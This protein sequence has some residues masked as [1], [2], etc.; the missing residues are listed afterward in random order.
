MYL[1][2]NNKSKFYQVVYFENG[3]RTTISTKSTHEREAQEFLIKFKFNIIEKPKKVIIQKE[4]C[5]ILSQ[6]KNEYFNYII[7]IKSK[8]YIR[9]IL[10]SFKQL[11]SF[12]GDIP[13]NSIDVKNIDH[14]VTSTFSRTKT[15]AHLYYRTLKAAFNK[16]IT[17]NYIS[18][19][20]FSKV[21]FPRISKSYPIFITEDE[22]FIILSNTSQKYLK[23]IFTVAFYSGLRISE[24]LNM[25]WNWINFFQ[26]LITVK[27]SNEF[28][29]KSKKERII[30]M[31]ERIRSILLSRFNSETQKPNDTVFSNQNGYPLLQNFVSK[32]FKKSVRKSNLND[33]IHFHTLRH[34][35][36]SLLAQKGVSLYVI[37]EL[38]GHEDIVT[39]Q[40]Y[41][42]L[43][44]QNLYDAVNFL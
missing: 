35:F 30:P 34:S 31:T 12:C 8:Q 1:T 36:A 14:F 3:K 24:I 7:P 20:P 43:Q 33:K 44:K 4:N 10:L 9:S 39:T 42:H 40:L 26:N 16:A 13:L 17:W 5:L 41:S 6:F 23:D 2:K 32:Q 29:T 15:G 11:I 37:K 25:K 28:I 27:C 18:V 38:L 22:L 21:K 19:N